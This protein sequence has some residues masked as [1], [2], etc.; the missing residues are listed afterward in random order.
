MANAEHLKLSEFIKK[1]HEDLRNDSKILGFDKA[2]DKHCANKETLKKY[3]ETM[4]E[5]S[6]T[7]WERNYKKE[8]AT[9]SSR[10]QWIYNYCKFYFYQ[11]ELVRQRMR[12]LDIAE[13]INTKIREIDFLN[14]CD[15]IRLLDVGSCYNPFEIFTCFDVLAL[16]IA[17]ANSQVK[18]CDFLNVEIT[19]DSIVLIDNGAVHKLPQCTYHVVLFSL[20]LEYLPSA[21]QRMLCCKKAYDLL[22]H[23]GLL[24]IITPDSKHVGANA[25]YMKSWRYN[26]AK[27]GFSR[28]KYEKLSHIHCMAFRKSLDFKIAERWAILQNKEFFDNIFIPQDFNNI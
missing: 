12:E 15:K 25:K 20:L 21:E 22:C 18:F 5:L 6:N 4:N 9:A 3:A 28:I 8:N 26:L 27:I 16:D 10:V 23:E 7:H 2:W 11:E 14:N 1:V 17:P 13:K 19:A 24:I